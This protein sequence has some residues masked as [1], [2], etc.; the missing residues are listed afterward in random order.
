MPQPDKGIMPGEISF[1]H[2]R[3]C[4]DLWRRYC[5][6]LDLTTQ[7]FMQIQEHLLKEQ[8]ELVADSGLGKTIMNGC[9]PRTIDELRRFVRLT[10]YQDYA[11]HL[12]AQQE[13]CLAAASF[14]WIQTSA[15]G[16]V[17]KRIPWS[18]RFQA[19][20]GRNIIAALILASGPKKQEVRVAPGFTVFTI[21]PAVP[22]ASAC[23]ASGL[24]KEFPMTI[25]PPLDSSSRMPFRRRVDEGLRLAIGAHVDYVVSMTSS[26][27]KIGER[28]D[29]LWK[30]GTFAPKSGSPPA[31]LLWKQARRRLGHQPH[32]T[33]G[34]V[35]SVK[36]VIGWGVDSDVFAEKIERQWG[37]P[38]FRMYASSEGGIMAMQQAIK[39]PMALLPDSVFFEFLPEDELR[40]GGSRTVLANELEDGKAYEPVLT[41]FY[42]MPLLRYRQ[43]DLLRVQ[44]TS[45]DAMPR[46]LFQGRADDVIDLFGIARLNG[47][48]VSRAL[49]LVSL[50]HG[51]WC[52]H[53]EYEASGT[54]L[55]LYVEL[56][57][58]TGAPEMKKLFHQALGTLDEHYREAVATMA[59]DPVAVTALPKGTFQ[60]LCN[61]ADGGAGRARMNPPDS[62]VQ[63]LLRVSGEMP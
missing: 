46:M 42:G 51:E 61:G 9:K 58:A 12:G 26:L 47:D 56:G 35:W 40:R 8:L 27:L 11:P 33:P 28:M 41:S 32:L 60:R 17:F 22:F 43:G 37:R 48:T 62:M 63:E 45:A 44:K 4:G 20:Q 57:E 31:K 53:K 13:D 7:E 16:G 50:D 36:G 14:S 1:F 25:I 29:E 2:N 39:G 21:L 55:R 52:L 23:I 18:S 30:H 10:T 5:G 54:I 34:E 15:P 49:E 59:C 24:A 19:A 38:L 3:D 6:F